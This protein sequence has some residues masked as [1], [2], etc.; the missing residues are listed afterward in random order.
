MGDRTGIEWTDATWNPLT[1]CTKVSQGCK[2]CYA[3]QVFPRPYT[4]SRKFTDVQCHPERLG[5]PLCWTRARRIFVNSMS[6]LFHEAVPDEFI[7]RAFAVMAHCSVVWY[8][9]RGIRCDHDPCNESRLERRDPHTM[10]ILTKRPAR[11]L[12]YLTG[13]NRLDAVIAAWAAMGWYFERPPF[14]D[15]QWPLPNVQLG[16]SVEDQETADERIPLLLETP[17]A[18][19]F[20]SAEPLLGAIDVR[21]WF[22]CDPAETSGHLHLPSLDWIIAGNE[23]GP[24]ARPMH[25]GWVRALRDQCVAAGVPFFFKQWGEWISV[26]EVEGDGKHFHFPDG[27][28]VRR[29]GKKAAGATLDGRAWREFPKV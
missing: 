3:E 14:D 7:D 26:S 22:C 23:S 13:P 27:T 2:N 18:V 8:R 12:E 29:I 4:H 11:A 16:V 17:A 24:R 6:D 5:P 10:Q 21:K 9:R 25:P 28:I 20:I 15:W 1:G 19:R